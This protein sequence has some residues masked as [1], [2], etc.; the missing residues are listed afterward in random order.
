MQAERR[1]EVEADARPLLG[2]LS[3]EATEVFGHVRPGR[4]E[5][6]QQQDSRRAERDAAGR[7]L[8]NRWLCQ[9]EVCGLN[10]VTGQA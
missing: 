1:A 2:E 3:A 5:V 10:D 4:E 7:A 8:W 6:R 9:F